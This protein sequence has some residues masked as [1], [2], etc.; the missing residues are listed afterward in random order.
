MTQTF[1]NFMFRI[2]LYWRFSRPVPL[3]ESTDNQ[4]LLCHA[5]GYIF[6]AVLEFTSSLK[7]PMSFDVEIRIDIVALYKD[8]E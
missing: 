1:M 5:M 6:S 8:I 4:I 3:H 7:I 2:L